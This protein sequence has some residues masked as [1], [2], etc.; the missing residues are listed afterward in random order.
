MT[1]WGAV[2]CSKLTNSILKRKAKASYLT[3]AMK[4]AQSLNKMTEKSIPPSTAFTAD[5]ALSVHLGLNLPTEDFLNSLVDFDTFTKE[6]K[7]KNSVHFMI[8]NEL[9][10]RFLKLL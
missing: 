2:K 9:P 6:I 5:S 8:M 4:T 3:G 1:L 10:L 7:K